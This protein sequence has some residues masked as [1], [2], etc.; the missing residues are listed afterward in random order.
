MRLNWSWSLFNS[1]LS[2][3]PASD[4]ENRRSQN[5][6]KFG[7]LLLVHD[8]QLCC[9]SGVKSATSITRGDDFMLFVLQ[10]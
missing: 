8:S 2:S 7:L 9:F 6:D 1:A 4:F 10:I 5:A 3:L